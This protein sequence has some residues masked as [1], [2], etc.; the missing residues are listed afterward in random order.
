MQVASLTEVEQ[1]SLQLD[2]GETLV[3]VVEPGDPE[4]QVSE[5]REH[6]NFAIRLRVSFHREAD[7]LVADVVEHGS[8]PTAPSP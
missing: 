3:F 8:G 4:V 5:L 2:S 6:Y 7:D 1:F